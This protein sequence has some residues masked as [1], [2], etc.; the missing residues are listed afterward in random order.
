MDQKELSP[1][2]FNTPNAVLSRKDF[3]PSITLKFEINSKGR[4]VY[5]TSQNYTMGTRC[6]LTHTPRHTEIRFKC[7]PLVYGIAGIEEIETCKYVLTFYSNTLCA[8]PGFQPPADITNNIECTTTSPVLQ[9]TTQ[10]AQFAKFLLPPAQL[11][12]LSFRKTQSEPLLF[13]QNV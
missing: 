6:D 8:F 10:D 4:K 3:D 1:E 5:Y 12:P 11:G 7:N 2:T 9:K 13:F